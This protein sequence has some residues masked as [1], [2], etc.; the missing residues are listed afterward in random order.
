MSMRFGHASALAL[1]GWY[2]MVP[3]SPGKFDTNAPLAQWKQ[4]QKIVFNTAT[5]CEQHRNNAIKYLAANKEQ[6]D[7]V[8][9]AYFIRLY[10]SAQCVANDDPRL[11]ENASLGWYLMVP[12]PRSSES[13]PPALSKWSI[14]KTYHS[15]DECEQ[16][17]SNIHSGVLQDPPP[18]FTQ[19]FG[20]N[21]ESSF[22][23]ADC[24]ASYDSRLKE[25]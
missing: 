3:P 6:I 9:V 17:W 4:D 24:I 19:R 2:L 12:P 13:E 18:D 25:K 1:L 14:Y 23:R 15:A 5:S 21:F 10:Q 11:K 16:A 20:D 22:A 8:R 7:K